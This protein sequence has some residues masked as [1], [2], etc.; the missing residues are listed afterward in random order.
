MSSTARTSIALAIG[1]GALFAAATAH[2]QVVSS[3]IVNLPISAT[4]NG[5]YLNVVTGANNLPGSTGGST[6]P[7]W[8]INPWSAT[9]IAFFSPAAPA[10]GAYVLAATSTVA[11]LAPGNLIGGTSTFGSGT[12]AN[13]AQWTLNSSDN[14]FGFRFNNE[15]GGTLHYGWAQ[16]RFGASL[17]DRTLVQY[18][19][20][21]TPGASIAVVP[22]PGTYAMMGLGVIALLVARRR[23]S[24]QA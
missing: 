11:N 9:G 17:T 2:A 8:D 6:V 10:G 7:G 15:A 3:G 13:V 12:S 20:D 1:A 24:K 23:Q 16:I 4:L 22:E 21:A 14:F 5:L 18:A 19:F